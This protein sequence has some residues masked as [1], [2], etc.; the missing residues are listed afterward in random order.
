MKRLVA[1]ALIGATLLAA[2][3]AGAQWG[4]RRR[5]GVPAGPVSR[6]GVPTW[7]LNK[8]VPE[9]VFTF[10]R[11]RYSS[12]RGS[13]RIDWP[14]ADLNLSFRLQQLTSLK[15][16]PEGKIIDVTDEALREYPFVYM[17]EPG[18]LE[19]TDPEVGALRRY[20][21]GGGFMMVDDFWG[22]EEWANFY[23]EM[24]RVFPEREPQDLDI[25]H[26][27]FHAVFPLKAKPQMPAIGVWQYQHVTY[28]RDD[29]KEVHYRAY[30]D[31]Q[32]RMMVIV[33]HNTDL[34]DGW[35]REGEDPNYFETFSE[36]MAYPMAINI[37]FYAM[38][39]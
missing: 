13:W 16:H 17:V 14:M 24:K 29:A 5:R 6:E 39:H 37:I 25:T 12:W 30:F 27:I 11:L 10:A 26:P 38:T 7:E 2:G 33:C 8:E 21:L 18:G 31:D 15:V 32:R 23:K 9:D 34:G 19:L 22:E 28:E 1:G 35:E 3:W 4:G 36:K 20:L